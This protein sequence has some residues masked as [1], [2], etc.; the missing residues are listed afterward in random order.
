[1]TLLSPA[2]VAIDCAQQPSLSCA[3]GALG[4]V[5]QQLFSAAERAQ[6]ELDAPSKETLRPSDSE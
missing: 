2:A 1:M 4:D 3:V 5:V 6:R